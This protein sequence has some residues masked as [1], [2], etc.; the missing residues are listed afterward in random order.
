MRR[1]VIRQSR[2]QPTPRASLPA[3]LTEGNAKALLV[4][5]ENKKWIFPIQVHRSLHF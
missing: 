1:A 4:A 3:F 2:V 5:V